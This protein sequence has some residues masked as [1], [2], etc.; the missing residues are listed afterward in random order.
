[1]RNWLAQHRDAFGRAARRLAGS[2][3]STLLAAAVIGIALAL[4][5]AGEV[6][7][8]NLL[9]LGSGVSGRP[10]LSV[11]LA[12]EADKGDAARIQARLRRTEG[13]RSFRFVA[14]EQTLERLRR[15]EGLAEVLDSL[16]H[17][18]FPD[19]FVVEPADASERSLA[20]LRETIAAWPGVEHVQLDNAWVKR[21][22]AL[23]GIARGALLALGALLATALVVITFNTIRLQILGQRDEIELSRLLGATDGFIRRP[24]CYFGALQ[25]LA[26]GA[27]AC[28]IVL[29][30]LEAVRAPL[31]ELAGLYNL[32]FTLRDPTPGD[33][34]A[35]LAAAA[36]LGW[37]GAWLSVSRHLREPRAG[38]MPAAPDPTR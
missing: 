38:A 2:P 31:T 6:L 12:T 33:A 15:T 1:M 8:R 20:Q 10:E 37:L 32:A 22:A 30:S 14:R 23:L 36:A 16:P 26:G 4:P 27:V 21:L 18:P 25:G 19:A 13:A 35:L 29:G 28:L 17:N 3:V 5:A 34:A 7:L 24:L 9:A 11:F